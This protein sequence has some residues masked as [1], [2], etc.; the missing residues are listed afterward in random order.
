MGYRKAN[1]VLPQDLIR[2]IQQYVDGEILYIPK[3]DQQR[4]CWGV[5][6]GA[7]EALG[8]RNSLIY[9]E[10]CSGVSVSALADKYYLSDKS[11]RRII[12]YIKT[13]EPA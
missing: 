13:N 10:Y 8:R 2:M 4:A 7:K 9:R 5:R 1:E 11:I 3:K 6:S 12:R